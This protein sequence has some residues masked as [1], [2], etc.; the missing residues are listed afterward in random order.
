MP[1]RASDRGR[2]YGREEMSRRLEG[3]ILASRCVTVYGPSGAG[4][5]SIVQASV[6]P[7][8]I[9]SEGVR[10][11]RVDAW[12]EGQDPTRW[13]AST[14]YGDLNLGDLPDGM[15]PREAVLTAARRAARGSPRLMIVYLD[16]LE[17]LLYPGRTLEET[18]PFFESLHALVDLPLR[19]VR[20]V[21][22]LREDYLGRF[23]DRLRDRPR[24][25]ENGFRVGPLTVAELTEA[26]CKAAAA[27]EPPQTWSPEPMKALMLQVRVP[28]QAA[29]E[30]AEAQ[31]AYA[32]IVCRA[33]FQERAQGTGAETE[34][35][36]AEPILQNY[37]EATLAE[38]GEAREAAQR[39][40]EDHLVTADGSRTLRTEKE[41][42]RVVPAAELAPI[43]RALEGAAILHAEEHQGSRYF[44]IGHDWL[45]RR[46]FEQRQEREL[47]EEQRRREAEQER[48]RELQ[49]KEVEARL[50]KA[51]AQRRT[52]M[53]IAGASLAV[54]GVTGAL[55]LWAVKQREEAR[56]QREKADA[57]RVEAVRKR[58]EAYD[59]RILAGFLALSNR[60]EAAWAMKLLPEVKRPAERPGWVSYAS[61]A[62]ASNA[63]RV[64]LRGHTASLSAAV[65]SPDGKR[66]ITASADGT[67]R[68]FRA[69]GDGLPVVLKGHEAAVTSA[70]VSPDGRLVLTTS[71]DGTARIFHLEGSAPPVVLKGAGGAVVAG[72]WSPDSAR[73]VTAS[74]DAVARVYAADG[75]GEATE[76]R[77]HDG[78]LTEVIFLPD[79]ARVATASEDGTAR[80]VRAD[81]KGAPVALKGHEGSVLSVT[82]S[83]DG[84]RIVTT[85]RDRTARIW[86]AGGRGAP[87]V[88]KG[89]EADV[90][91][92][93]V[94]SDGAR[95][96]T[97]SGDRTARVW[98]VDGGGELAVLR[99]HTL[100]V[101][102]VAFGPG[103]RFVATA[104]GDGTARV[105]PADGGG[106]PLVLQGHGAPLRSVAWSPDGA[107]LLTAAADKSERSQDRTAK[108]WS[109][110]PLASLP[111]AQKDAGFFHAA[112][113]SA[114]GALV[115][116]A[117]DDSTARLRRADGAG[118]P[119]VFKGHEGWVASASLSPKGDRVVT[120]SFDK[121]ARVWPADGEGDPVVLKGHEAEVRFAAMSPDGARVV[122]ASDDRT[123]RVWSADGSGEPVV[124][125]GHGD[126]LTAAAISPDGAR[127][128]T[129]SLD[130]TARVWSMGGG[131]A[132]VVLGGHSGAVYA[133][134]W[135]KGGARVVTASEDGAARVFRADG[136]GPPVVLRG[137][138]APMLRAA[139]SEDGG[140]VAASSVDGQ[141]YVWRADGAGP[142]V[143]IRA[144]SPVI[145]LAF[146]EGDQRLVTVGADNSVHA[147]MIDVNALRERLAEAHADCLPAE[148]RTQFLGE[149]AGY[150]RYAFA[151]CESAHGRMPAPTEKPPGGEEVPDAALLADAAQA[152][153]ERASSG[154]A[155]LGEAAR[156][157]PSLK[158][159][160][161]SGRR[162]KV[163]VLPGDAE[164]EIA[165]VV[166]RRRDGV[167]ELTGKVGDVRRL[168]VSKGA[169]YIEQDVTIKDWS[170]SPELIDLAAK[171]LAR[172]A[173][174]GPLKPGQ[175]KF[176]P[177]MPDEFE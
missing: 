23:R 10:V 19:N 114:D 57:A 28:G 159:L 73:V 158:D 170:A 146:V 29:T 12:P 125:R 11:T 92:A 85:S 150:A 111:R 51:R 132:P 171:I 144:G 151:A 147:W 56:A 122:T 60:G 162:V 15:E 126:W 86:D 14:V 104:S 58:V 130:H 47:R 148:V 67:A 64:T 175:G 120:A 62:L 100:A 97:A 35:V 128:V 169:A 27:G 32:Q 149:T 63:L 82:A 78:P 133:A 84:K 24:V 26:V 154:G 163:T 145:A 112:A 119:V 39:L 136:E 143:V 99:G 168:R 38:L 5:S 139:F 172:S 20:V 83:P 18:E 33:L 153:G 96:A 87:V 107:L 2:F 95:V 80:V 69:D 177:L 59:Q 79:G 13:L 129:T 77:G 105:W 46:V 174:T 42:L 90:Y 103:G 89:H 54:A 45:A 134:A 142:P 74:D 106:A 156:A 70:A 166:A 17:Q 141:I 44:E 124:L 71:E 81:G 135:D 164:I 167:V 121:T 16:Q 76:L 50:K 65:F 34:A 98:S 140:R 127:V 113:M 25:V 31:S 61:D 118:E 6:L 108:V 68:V 3:S 9:E 30:E 36:E 138:D 1:Y 55:G 66:V 123:A 173:P 40:L 176:A 152:T 52:L 109:A 43:L 93:A 102:D 49:R 72:A 7:G 21:L 91:R 161:P 157:L 88:L 137:S 41:L 22:S 165:G 75:S 48:E 101:T 115:V 37:L 160:G 8:L 94:S 117:Y 155:A 110:E 53:F 131:G 4:K 116:A